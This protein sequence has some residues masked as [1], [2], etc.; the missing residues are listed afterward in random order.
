MGLRVAIIEHGENS[1]AGMMTKLEFPNG[2]N[3]ESDLENFIQASDIITL[4]NEFIDPDILDKIAERRQVYPSPA[5]MRLVPT[6]SPT[7]FT[8]FVSFCMLVIP[9]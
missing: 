4:E 9:F 3:S 7:A 1:P 2:W 8:C 5:T 6:S